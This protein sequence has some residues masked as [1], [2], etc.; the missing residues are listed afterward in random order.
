MSNFLSKIFAFSREEKRISS[1]EFEAAV[2]AALLSD[3]V[4]D[5]TKGPFISEE[6]A[7][8]LSAVWA[9]VLILSE[10]VGTL[11]VHLYHRTTDGRETV[12]NHPCSYILSK[13][14]SYTSRFALLHHLMVSCTLWGNGYARIHRDAL[15]R[16]VRLQLMHPTEVEPVHTDDD[17][18]YYRTY[19]GE[20]VPVYDMIHLRG[21]ST[22]GYKG[23]SPIAVHRE[24][25]SLT[26]TSVQ[27]TVNITPLFEGGDRTLHRGTAESRPAPRPRFY[28]F[29]SRQGSIPHIYRGRGEHIILAFKPGCD[30]EKG[31][32]QGRLPEPEAKQHTN[33]CQPIQ[34][35]LSVPKRV[36][37]TN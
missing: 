17:E 20:I 28:Y 27:W 29:A 10:T 31:A 12:R 18:L 6:G 23:K 32:A 9:C 35:L 15:F 16:T 13:P 25:L 14:N 5:A 33:K 37:N 36:C 22:N 2:N 26:G 8:N 3:T 34:I 1:S 4:A 11:P 19:K 24:N 21:L 30:K 7:L